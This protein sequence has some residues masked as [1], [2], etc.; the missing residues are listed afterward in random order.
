MLKRL[1]PSIVT[2]VYITVE[3]SRKP[4]V[5]S[6][7]LLAALHNFYTAILGLNQKQTQKCTCLKCG[8]R[9]EEFNIKI[10]FSFYV[11]QRPVFFPK[12]TDAN[13]CIRAIDTLI[14]T[15]RL[16]FSCKLVNIDRYPTRKLH[17]IEQKNVFLTWPWI[18]LKQIN[19]LFTLLVLFRACFNFAKSDWR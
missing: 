15:Q 6:K 10:L 11:L 17:G 18:I 13:D 4:K 3:S 14:P 5:Q 8:D 2:R 12:L 19:A 9:N 16:G 7:N 1:L